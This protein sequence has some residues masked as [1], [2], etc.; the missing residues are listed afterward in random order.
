MNILYKVQATQIDYYD[1][2]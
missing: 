1:Y 2:F